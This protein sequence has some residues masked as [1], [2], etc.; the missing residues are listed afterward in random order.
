MNIKERWLVA[1]TS[2][3]WQ[4]NSIQEAQ[5]L[6]LKVLAI[7]GD[8]F[9]E[10]GKYANKFLHIDINKYDEVIK[11]IKLLEID[12]YG[13]S[14]FISDAG[15][16]LAAKIREEFNLPGPNLNITKNLIEK[17]LQRKKWKE[18]GVASPEFKIFKDKKIAIE[19]LNNISL[20]RIIKPS[21]SAG[22][23]GV[24]K[25]ENIDEELLLYVDEAFKF[26]KTNEVIIESFMDGAEFTIEVVL[27]KK[28]VYILCI[29]EKL[30]VEGTNGTVAKELFTTE[31]D[32]W[33]IDLISKTV[34]EAFLSLGYEDG[35]GHAELILMNN[36]NVGMVEVA[37]RGGG[38][39]VA[40]KFVPIS[41]GVNVN[42]LTCKLA[43]NEVMQKIEIKKQ[44]TVLRFFPS[45]HGRVVGIDGFKE[46]N[47]IKGV[48]ANSFVQKGQVFRNANTD[49]DRLGYILSNA[50]TLQEAKDLADKAESLICF[51][52]EEI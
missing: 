37:G 15:M 45:I 9:A 6:G 28:I 51:D 24:R 35:P 7:D 21:D 16:L 10:G 5:K 8:P 23:R 3:R 50:N 2:G 48:E 41:S 19:H 42:A 38:Y 11:A 34:T 12:I 46:A 27:E 13:V 49:G 25:I 52:I 39:M 40:D 36:G 22:S 1:V 30:K 17:T 20:P 14:S 47:L 33:I 18:A 43:V 4:V 32:E 29:T 31:R 44:N 26:S